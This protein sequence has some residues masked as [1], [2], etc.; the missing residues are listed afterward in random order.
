MTNYM[1][2]VGMADAIK[3]TQ[4]Y[5]GDRISIP[6]PDSPIFVAEAGINHGG[7]MDKAVELVK[8][9][10]NAGAHIV[11]FQTHLPEHEMTPNHPLWDILSQCVLTESWHYELKQLADSLGLVFMS[12]PFCTQ[13]V[14]LLER[15]GVD[16]YKVGSGELTH[17]PLL[18]YIAGTK[19]PM[20]IS[21]GMATL[22][23]IN[24]ALDAV[25]DGGGDLRSVAL[26]NCTSTYPCQIH[27][28]RVLGVDLL[29]DEFAIPVGQSDH[30]PTI[31]SALAAIARGACI[32]EKHFTVSRDWE[33]PDIK[34]SLTPDEFRHMVTLGTEI[35]ESLEPRD[36]DAL[37]EGEDEIRAWAHHSLVVARKVAAGTS[38]RRGDLVAL[39]CPEADVIAVRYLDELM[40]SHPTATRDLIPGSPLLTTDVRRR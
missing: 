26:M 10:A 11:K 17:W 35:W 8:S 3:L 22:E 16:A 19:K 5:I 27:D 23:E 38:I 31:S 18:R 24:L 28:S 25:H 15:V 2:Y 20:I 21:T 6:D 40:D 34:S 12:T 29:R 14:D 37:V 33:G 32:I 1:N 4:F 36:P 39:R 13:A 30:T 9:A 7:D